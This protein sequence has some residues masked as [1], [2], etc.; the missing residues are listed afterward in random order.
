MVDAFQNSTRELWNLDGQTLILASGSARRK[1]LLQNLGLSFEVEVAAVVEDHPRGLQPHEVAVYLAEKK[2]LAVGKGQPGRTTLVLGADTVVILD[3]KVMGKPTTDIHA[4]KMLRALA[5]RSHE[6]VTGV[7]VVASGKI[8][9]GYES[10]KVWFSPLTEKEIMALVESNDWKDKA[11]GYG[12]QSMASSVI[13]RIEGDY[14]NV[15]GLPLFKTRTLVCAAAIRETPPP[16]LY[17]SELRKTL[18][19]EFK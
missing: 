12:I 6:V 8:Y 16:P 1:E 18:V 3:K 9:S 17:S 14:F 19:E 2:S 7:S 5:G 4:K 15:V 11:G 13:P 10:T